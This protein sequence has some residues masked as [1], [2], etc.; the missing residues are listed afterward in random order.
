MTGENQDIGD[1]VGIRPY[2]EAVK[3]LVQGVVDSAAA[4]LGRICLPASEEF[5]LLLKDKISAWRAK[6]AVA[7]VQRTEALLIETGGIGTRHAHP[8]LVLA[9]IEHGSWADESDVQ[10]MWAGLLASSCTT[11]GKD[12]TNLLFMNTL[13]QITTAQARIVNYSCENATKTITKAGL[14]WRDT[15]FEKV[16]KLMEIS[17]IGNI[18]QLDRELDYLRRLDL[19]EFGIEA[20]NVVPAERLQACISPSAFALHLYVKCQGSLQSPVEYFNVEK[21]AT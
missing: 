11:T 13:S 2:G 6:N 14:I 15:F 20:D 12:Q 8:R 16:T 4:F 21:E 9:A 7:I 1:L 10:D 3:I 19:I 17:G 18:H 5:G